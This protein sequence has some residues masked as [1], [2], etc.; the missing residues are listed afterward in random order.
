MNAHIGPASIK[1]SSFDLETS[2]G[3][4]AFPQILV[5]KE[6]RL[7]LSY[8]LTFRCIS[9]QQPRSPTC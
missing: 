3:A 5:S 1:E 9:S 8:F 2:S 6:Q 7:L 4:I